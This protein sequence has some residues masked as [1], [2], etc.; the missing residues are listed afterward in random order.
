MPMN[1]G[2]VQFSKND[3]LGES[4]EQG[5]TEELCRDFD[6]LKGQRYN[7]E[8]HW[9][10]IA[11]RIYPMHRNLFQSL[12]MRNMQGEKRNQDVLDSTGVIALQRF[13]AILDSLLTPRNSYWHLLTTDNPIL[14]K[15]KK[16]KDWFQSV[17]EILFKER[18]SPSANFASQNQLQYLSLGAYGTGALFID[19][20]MGKKGLR[21]R[22]CHLSEIY[23]QENHQGV[24][25]RV[26]RYF[27]MT[28][29]QTVQLFGDV[30]PE[31]IK[32]K[33]QTN[34]EENFYF[35]HW[36]VPRK[37]RD[38]ERKDFKGMEYA[39]YYISLT[40][41][42]LLAEGGY[43]SFPFAISR[44]YQA[45]LE[46]Y[47]RSPAMDALPAIKTLNKQKET[48]LKQ[49]QLAVDP[50]MLLHDDGIM[51]GASLEP[52]TFIP[53]AVSAE[54]RL[55]AQPLPV[56]RVD[57]GKEFMEEERKIVNDTFLVNLFQILVETPEMTAT[58]VAERVREKSILL[59]PTI[60][61]QQSEYLE[62]MIERELDLLSQQGKL[63]PMPPMLREAE[64]EYAIVHDSPISRTQKSEWVAGAMRS[65]EMALNIASQMQ[66]PS[67][68]DYYNFHEI[69]PQAAEIQGT[70]S[71]WMNSPDQV[72]QLRAARA[73]QAQTQQMIEAAPAVAGVIKATK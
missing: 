14:K 68:L 44:Y 23:L 52:G 27:M 56:G 48:M 9:N 3:K 54:G 20:L 70:P 16:T 64:G 21:Y 45:P 32:G 67:Y 34:P 43:T 55:L 22:N 12:L 30:T 39:S 60:G 66:D 1:E 37:D 71:S 13:G 50:V 63:P 8:N 11:S 29:R 5:L 18:Y 6:N 4:Y 41:K 31:S 24:I 58:E 40:E 61:R 15:D 65:I 25:D 17:N 35:L 46:V 73:Q 33:A 2:Y 26:C 10:E 59:A 28:A 51:D 38:P 53:G 42:K 36:V 62:P 72:A 47:G 19:N 57:I 49:G 7:F 69:I